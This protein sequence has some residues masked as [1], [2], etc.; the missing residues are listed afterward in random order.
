[1]ISQV[2][3]MEKKYIFID[4]DGTTLDHSADGVSASTMKAYKD[5]MSNGHEVFIATGRP[6]A[7]FYGVDELLGVESYIGANGRIVVYK[8]KVIYNNPI[9]KKTTIEF[10]EKMDRIGIDVGYETIDDYFVNSKRNSYPDK[11]SE[12]FHLDMPIVKK[13][14]Y[15]NEDV[16]QMILYTDLEGFNKAREI[17]PNIHY[18]YS[19]QYGYDV[20]DSEGLK[21]VGIKAVVEYLGIDIK[22]C[23]ALGDGFNDIS[24]LKYAGFGIAM[25]NAYDEVKANA[26]MVTDN[27]SDDGLYKAFKKIGLI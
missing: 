27:I 26:D 9:S 2:K 10:T 22:D 1:M 4:L 21:D 8:G 24:M 16:Y 11:F 13:D 20:T 25:G 7:L 18:S 15:K 6:P 5:L 14:K 3:S 19:N 12:V 23:I 17:Y